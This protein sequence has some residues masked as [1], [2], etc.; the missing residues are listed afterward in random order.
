MRRRS[1]IAR[2][3]WAMLR[4]PALSVDDIIVEPKPS[5]KRRSASEQTHALLGLSEVMA[6][7]PERAVQRLV[8]TAM[9]LTEA[10]SAGISL[11]DTHE[12]QPVFRWVAVAGELTRYLHAT[13]PR[14]FSPCGTVVA[15]GKTLVMRDLV[16]FFPYAADFHVP[17]HISL[18]T[19]YGRRGKL[20]GT[21]WMVNHDARKEFGSEDVRIVEQMTTFSTAILD[22]VQMR[23]GR[24]NASARGVRGG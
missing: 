23:S 24:E 15:R 6:H 4:N 2:L 14:D 3:D 17:L 11:E 12:S 20:V 22:S 21:V 19:P 8:E 7:A 5:T 13:M 18:L 10:D 9:K 1:C 16:R